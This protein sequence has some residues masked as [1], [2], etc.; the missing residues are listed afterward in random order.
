VTP[1]YHDARAAHAAAHRAYRDAI[2][3]ADHDAR[4]AHD[5]ARRAYRAAIAAADAARDAH[6]AKPA[7]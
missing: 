2:A 4:A 7:P 5:A 6:A 1:A 3:A